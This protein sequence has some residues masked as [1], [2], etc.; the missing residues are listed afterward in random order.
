MAQ[1]GRLLLFATDPATQF[2]AVINQNAG[3]NLALNLNGALGMPTRGRVV[4]VS[5]RSVQNLIWEVYFWR[6]SG[7]NAAIGAGGY[8]GRVPFVV[9]DGSQIGGAGLF[10]YQK[11]ADIPLLNSVSGDDL[12]YLSLVNRSVASAGGANQIKIELMIDPTH[13]G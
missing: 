6:S 10:H 9:A 1:L 8:A 4:A 7:Y 11:S 2:T 13:G 5:I 3:A 12:L